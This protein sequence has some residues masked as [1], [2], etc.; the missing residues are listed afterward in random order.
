LMEL[1]IYPPVF[2]IWKWNY[3]VKPVLKKEGAAQQQLLPEDAHV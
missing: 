1:I 2:A 3:E